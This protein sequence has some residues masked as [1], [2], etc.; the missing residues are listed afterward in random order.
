MAYILGAAHSTGTQFIV[1]NPADRG[2]GD[3]LHVDDR[4]GPLWLVP[5]IRLLAVSAA[6]AQVT[7]AQCMFGAAF[8]KYTTFMHTPGFQSALGPLAG[9]RC[10]H[11]RGTHRP[12]GGTKSPKGDWTS[13]ESAAFPSDLNTFLVEACLSLVAPSTAPPVLPPHSATSM[14]ASPAAEDAAASARRVQ[15]PPTPRLRPPHLRRLLNH[16]LVVPAPHER[17]DD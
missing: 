12:A 10:T 17:R 8:Q 5:I 1:E 13:S 15:Q 9:L 6:T 7:F 14:A 4:H 3:E 2:L 11:P 16:L